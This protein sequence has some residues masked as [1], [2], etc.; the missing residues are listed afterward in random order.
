MSPAA[1]IKSSRHTFSEIKYLICSNLKAISRRIDVV[2]PAKG[3]TVKLIYDWVSHNRGH[4]C[5]RGW[6]V[7]EV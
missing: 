6:S 3:K 4:L 7:L 5:G 1:F 2:D